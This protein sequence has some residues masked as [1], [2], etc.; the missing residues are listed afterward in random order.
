MSHGKFPWFASG[1]FF[2]WKKHVRAGV[3]GKGGVLPRLN[4]IYMLEKILKDITNPR[5]SLTRAEIVCLLYFNSNKI[6]TTSQTQ[7]SPILGLE[8]K[9][10]SRAIRSLEG[11]GLIKR[12]KIL[13]GDSRNKRIVFIGGKNE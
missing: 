13:K 2:Y 9:A 11:R 7:L 12:E 8:R 3:L 6:C 10:I 5:D 4:K 1:S